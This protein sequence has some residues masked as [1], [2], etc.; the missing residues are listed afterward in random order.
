[1]I[2]IEDNSTTFDPK[3]RKKERKNMASNIIKIMEPIIYQLREN[4]IHMIRNIQRMKQYKKKHKNQLINKEHTML[5]EVCFDPQENITVYLD[6]LCEKIFPLNT[7]KKPLQKRIQGAKLHQHNHE[8]FEMF[9]LYSGG[10][11]CCLGDREIELQPGSIWILNT[12]LPHSIVLHD[13]STNLINILV[14]SSSFSH[15]L[16]ELLKPD[17]CFYHFFVNDVFGEETT[18]DYMSFQL[19]PDSMSEIYLSQILKEY[20]QQEKASQTIMLYLFCCLLVELSRLYEQQ[21]T[22]K[23]KDKLSLCDILGYMKENYTSVTL[24]DLSE[25]FHYS[26]HYISEL[27]LQYTGK[28]FLKIKN[29]LCL[30]KAKE[31]LANTDLSIDH[32][33]MTVGYEYRSSFDAT[34]K[35][36]FHITPK[37]YRK[38]LDEIIIHNNKAE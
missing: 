9:Y 38:Q 37:Q 24:Q 29:E 36:E 10:C 14:R 27:L 7:A 28:R 3:R 19:E 16:M 4:P 32:I 2:N 13:N 6:F 15:T 17:N 35:K 22:I 20:L 11:T 5:E 1:M 33:A 23:A 18:A 12:K 26:S 30:K 31:M 25:H 21:I 8:F 34:F